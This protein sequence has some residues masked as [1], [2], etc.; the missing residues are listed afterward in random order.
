MGRLLAVVV[1]VVAVTEH[2]LP[3]CGRMCA[4]PPA[5]GLVAVDFLYQLVEPGADRAE[6]TELGNV[7]AES[8][9]ESVIRT[10]LID[11][12]RVHLEP[13]THQARVENPEDDACH[14]RAYE[15]SRNDLA[16][17]HLRSSLRHCRSGR[18]LSG[19]QICGSIPGGSCWVD[20]ASEPSAGVSGDHCGYSIVA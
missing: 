12:A 8:R 18:V 13:V 1:G 6:D 7:R 20:G 11:R 19:R 4:D 3:A 17:L 15:A 16:P 10:R 14:S 9:P 5:A 2:E